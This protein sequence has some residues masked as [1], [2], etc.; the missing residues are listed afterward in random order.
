MWQHSYHIGKWAAMNGITRASTI[1]T[2]YAAGLDAEDAFKAGF[3]DGGGTLVSSI[4][5]PLRSPDYVP[6]LERVRREKPQ[7]LTDSI[8]VVLKRRASSRRITI[9]ASRPPASG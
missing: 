8:P 3:A 7:A 2:D 1:V 4:R 6:F 9:S 5:A